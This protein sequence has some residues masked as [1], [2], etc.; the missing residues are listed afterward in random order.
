MSRSVEPIHFT[1]VVFS[2]VGPTYAGPLRPVLDDL[3]AEVSEE[4]DVTPHAAPRGGA[5]REFAV[6]GSHGW[7]RTHALWIR[8]NLLDEGV[9]KETTVLTAA[10]AEG[11]RG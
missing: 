10:Q 2:A 5:S 8:S 6:D 4:A 11:C 7:L 9:A 3:P 1:S